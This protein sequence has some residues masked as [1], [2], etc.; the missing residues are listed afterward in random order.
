MSLVRLGLRW[1][2]ASAWAPSAA[3]RMACSSAPTQSPVRTSG[4]RL[5][6]LQTRPSA[7]VREARPHGPAATSGS[8][9]VGQGLVTTP[10]SSRPHGADSTA[11]RPCALHLSSVERCVLHGRCRPR[12]LMC[13]SLVQGGVAVHPHLAD[14]KSEATDGTRADRLRVT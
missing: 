6:S 4:V 9:V 14:W 2:A 7:V 10:P 12:Q 13:S 11:E 3:D 1:R 5:R 8:S